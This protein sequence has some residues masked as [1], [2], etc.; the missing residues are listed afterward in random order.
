MRVHVFTG[1]QTKTQLHLVAL[2]QKLAKFHLHLLK[3]M[4]QIIKL[5]RHQQKSLLRP[6]YSKASLVHKI[7]LKKLLLRAHLVRALIRLLAKTLSKVHPRP[8]RILVLQSLRQAALLRL[9]FR[10]LYPQALLQTQFL[11]PQQ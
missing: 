10:H 4:I 11:V 3:K 6:A 8:L 7:I 1:V 9:K 5:F 2:R